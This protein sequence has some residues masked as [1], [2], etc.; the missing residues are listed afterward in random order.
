[1]NSSHD[2]DN[3]LHKLSDDNFRERLL[4]D[5]IHVLSS[6]G[7][8][9]D[10]GQIPAI[11]NLPSKTMVSAAQSTFNAKLIQMADPIEPYR[12]SEIRKPVTA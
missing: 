1:M 6:I 11:R 4:S 9:I 8:Q 10:Q 3:L 5:P 7:I 2:I 12:L